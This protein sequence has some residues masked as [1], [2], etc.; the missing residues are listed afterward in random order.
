MVIIASD[1]DHISDE[2]P[3]NETLDLFDGGVNIF[4]VGVGVRLNESTM[5]NLASAPKNYV[6]IEEWLRLLDR[7]PTNL[8]NGNYTRFGNGSISADPM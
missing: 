6:P 4:V 2:D 7:R 1:G 5:R 8:Q 3:H